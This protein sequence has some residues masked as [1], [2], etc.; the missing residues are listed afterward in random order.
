MTSTNEYREEVN[1]LIGWWQDRT[2]EA[3]THIS[4]AD[5]ADDYRVHTTESTDRNISTKAFAKRLR[6]TKPVRYNGDSCTG[7][8]SRRVKGGSEFNLGI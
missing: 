3:E 6:Q 7:V 4:V 1:P 8:E 5:L 2:E